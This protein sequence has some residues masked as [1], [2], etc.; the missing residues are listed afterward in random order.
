MKSLF[1]LPKL[2]IV[3]M[4]TSLTACFGDDKPEVV[5]DQEVTL[6]YTQNLVMDLDT[7]APMTG[8]YTRE[9]SPTVPHQGTESVKSVNISKFSF[10]VISFNNGTNTLT[11]GTFKYF[12]MD[13]P[14]DVHTIYTIPAPG[15][16]LSDLKLNG[17]ESVFELSDTDKVTLGN[18][19]KD[20]KPFK[21]ILEATVDRK[22]FTATMALHVE[23]KAV[24]K[25][26]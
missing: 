20:E 25:T 16:K 23:G 17:T 4:L 12:P 8:T 9:L 18:L 15:I 7:A 10:K 13:N 14:S 5:P 21:V 6:D 19:I 3:V 22:P 24:L 1:S 11:Y 26:I 2:S